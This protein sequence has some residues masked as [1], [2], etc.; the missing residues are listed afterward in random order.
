V[1]VLRLLMHL[2]ASHVTLLP[3][4]F[5]FFKFPQI[6]LKASGGLTLGFA[7]NF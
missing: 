6:K 5:Y 4:E 2:S 7:P 3:R 1:R